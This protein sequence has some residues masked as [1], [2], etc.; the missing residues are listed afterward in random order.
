MP[1]SATPRTV[2]LQAPLSMG[3]F[4][5]NT[6]MGCHFL[7]QGIFPTQGSNPRLLCLLHWQAGSLPLAPP[8]KAR[9][10]L[11]V[12]L[13]LHCVASVISDSV[14][15][16][17]LQPVRLLY[18]WDSPGKSSRVGCHTLL[19]EIFLTQGSNLGLLH[20]RQIL[21][22]CITREA[23]LYLCINIYSYSDSFPL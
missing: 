5:K 17:G 3:F 19:Q 14:G 11:P 18:P 23:H 6:G 21:Y 10:Y 16:Y 12:L 2:A 4:K 20:C 7:L 13:L 9:M 15:P 22:C 1:D 8:G